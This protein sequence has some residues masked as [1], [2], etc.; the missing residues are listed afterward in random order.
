MHGLEI[1]H[2]KATS[3]T[4][5]VRFIISTGMGGACAPAGVCHGGVCSNAQLLSCGRILTWSEQPEQLGVLFG[6]VLAEF[7]D[8][9]DGGRAPFFPIPLFIW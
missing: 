8:L 7:Q 6:E 3:L 5:G 9:G 2:I 1:I 4:V